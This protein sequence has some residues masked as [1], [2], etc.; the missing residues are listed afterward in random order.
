MTT[1]AEPRDPAAWSSE[2]QRWYASMLAHCYAFPDPTDVHSVLAAVSAKPSSECFN[3]VGDA[4]LEGRVE[5]CDGRLWSDD[6][7]GRWFA[8]VDRKVLWLQLHLIR[9]A[10]GQVPRGGDVVS[11]LCGNCGCMRVQHLRVQSRAQDARD[12]EHHR[13]RGAGVFR[14]EARAPESPV[15]CQNPVRRSKRVRSPDRE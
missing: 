2:Q 10:C 13:A 7:K 9:I 1:A 14:V 11:H 15:T 4:S 5:D 3:M 8:T 12:R 6:Q